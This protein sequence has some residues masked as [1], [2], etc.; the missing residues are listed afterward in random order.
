MEKENKSSRSFDLEK[1]AKHSFDLEKKSS[2]RFNLSKEDEAKDET[3]VG[4]S[5]DDSGSSARQKAAAKTNVKKEGIPLTETNGKAP[6]PVKGSQNT[7][8]KKGNRTLALV[9]V[10]VVA[11]IVVGMVFF[12][13]GNDNENKTVAQP[14]AEQTEQS[15]D[16]KQDETVATTGETE[17]AQEATE[18]TPV[19]AQPTASSQTAVTPPPAKEP[20]KEVSQIKPAT[21]ENST[22]PQLASTIEEQARQVIRGD[23]GNG[24]ERKR[25]LGAAYNEIQSMVNELYRTGN[26]KQ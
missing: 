23:F 5:T 16:E 4:S 22:I 9:A 1:G 8:G 14:V 20:Q 21:H 11:L 26:W 19:E 3:A 12:F 6:E 2:R 25:K 10:A 7:E 15:T 13:K 17:S 24:E 18:Q